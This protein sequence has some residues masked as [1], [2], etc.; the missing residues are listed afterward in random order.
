MWLSAAFQEIA[1]P[2]SFQILGSHN[3]LIE[4]RPL[5]AFIAGCWRFFTFTQLGET[6]RYDT[7]D[8]TGKCGIALD[9]SVA[10]IAFGLLRVFNKS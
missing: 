5:S 2:T 1:L 6:R 9:E 3:G 8:R 7:G 4:K 10:S